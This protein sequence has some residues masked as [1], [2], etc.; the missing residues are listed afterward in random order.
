MAERW[1]TELRKIDRVEPSLG[2][3]ERAE[4][5]PFLP[6]TGPRPAARATIV[7][8][9]LLVAAAGSWGAFAALRGTS[10][11]DHGSAG[12]PEAFAALWPET[13]LADARQIQ[14]RVD[15][16]DPVVRWRTEAADVALR[17]A[18][19]VLGWPEPIAGLTAPD[20]SDTAIV[21]LHGPDASCSGAECQG[22]QPQQIAVT[23]TVQRLVRSGE[24]GIWSVTAV[25]SADSG[26]STGEPRPRIGGWPEDT[27]G[28]GMISDTGDERI[29]ELIKAVGDNGVSGYVRYEDSNGPQ[30][31]DPAEA[32]AMSGKEYVIPVYAA[33][34][35]TVIDWLTLSSG[36]G[37]PSPPPDG[38]EGG[39]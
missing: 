21:S 12:G 37:A 15:A 29:P 25:N 34:G 26:P 20:G 1:L 22:W 17:Y 2:L 35:V 16:G 28:D 32:V 11:A 30:A 6:D 24:G 4:A 7:V 19:E 36:E 31:S 10:P 3:L 8:V 39:H 18:Q 13:S 5:G 33:D 23:V 9:A 14:A 27:N 38:S